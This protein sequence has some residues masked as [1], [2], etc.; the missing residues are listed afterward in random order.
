LVATLPKTDGEIIHAAYIKKALAESLAIFKP[1]RPGF[2]SLDW[3][4]YCSEDVKTISHLPY[5]PNIAPADCFLFQ[6]VKLELAGLYL[7]QDSFKTS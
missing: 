6:W 3:F 1:K 4:L 5:S 7:S 2:S